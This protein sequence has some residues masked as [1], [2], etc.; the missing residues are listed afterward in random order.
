MT[1]HTRGLAALI[2]AAAVA[3]LPLMAADEPGAD[4]LV[5]KYVEA[6]G[7]QAKLDSVKTVHIKAK[8][9][10]GGGQ[11]E[12]PMDVQIKRP[13]L[14]YAVIEFQGKKIVD[15]FDGTTKWSINPMSG[16]NDPQKADEEQTKVAIEQGDQIEGAL[17]NYKAKGHTLEL[18]GKEDVEGTP[19][20]KLKLTLKSGAVQTI[21]LDASNYLEVKTISKRK[22]MGQEM[23]AENYP[24]NYKSVEGLMMPFSAET[25]VGG[26]SLMQMQIEKIDINPPVD[27]AIF[28]M[29]AP[30]PQPKKEEPK[31][32]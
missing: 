13:N 15:A 2:F 30:A 24:G 20:F 4:D 29:P 10:M 11:M 31:K 14:S 26:R 17:I 12:L 8:M 16:S 25:K 22:M 5:K 9:M 7:G 32:Q 27:E 18:L 19:T 21:F 6:R 1:T 28:K 3:A 23:E